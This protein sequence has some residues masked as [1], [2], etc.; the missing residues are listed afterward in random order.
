MG[1]FCRGYWTRALNVR[2]KGFLGGRHKKWK[3][4][5]AGFRGPGK[6]FHH[7]IPPPPESEKWIICF[8]VDVD[9]ASSRVVSESWTQQCHWG[10]GRG[11]D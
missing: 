1:L 8:S 9:F 10:W 7:L 6:L 11:G 2:G 4:P 3:G 5:K